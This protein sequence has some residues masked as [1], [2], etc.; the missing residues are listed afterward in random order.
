[1]SRDLRRWEVAARMPALAANRRRSGRSLAAQ[2][3]GCLS[4]N[5]ARGADWEERTWAGE[6]ARVSPPYLGWLAGS[7]LQNLETRSNERS[8][9]FPRPVRVNPEAEEGASRFPRW[10]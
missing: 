8:P 1:M 4:G 2:R 3:R 9:T 10:R 5:E 7:G 6:W